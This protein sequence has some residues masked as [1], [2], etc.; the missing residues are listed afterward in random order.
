ML[1][2]FGIV[3]GL[4][5]SAEATNWK[6]GSLNV[7]SHLYG[8]SCPARNLCVAVGFGGTVATTTQPEALSSWQVASLPD[9]E[10]LEGNLRGVSCPSSALCVATD[11]SG[12]VWISSDPAA[13]ASAWTGIPVPGSKPYAVS[14]PTVSFCT[15]VGMKGTVL[16]SSEP[17]G[18][19]GAWTLTTLSGNPYMHAVSCASPVLCVA[20]D[21]SGAVWSTK[22]P[23]SGA[24][25]WSSG[26]LLS[27]NQTSTMAVACPLQ[28]FCVAG[29]AGEIFTTS[30]PTALGSAWQ[31][32]PLASR[33]QVLS[34]SC[35]TASLCA[36]G[37]DNGQIATS[38]DPSGGL[39][40]WQEVQ[41][42]DGTTNAFYGIS[43]PD[44]TLCVAVG[45]AGHVAV[46]EDPF[47]LTGPSSP[48]AA[49]ST[50]LFGKRFRRRRLKRGKATAGIRFHFTANGAVTGFECK[51]D[52]QR[53]LPCKAPRGYRL[54][55]GLHHFAVR[56][57]GPG[58]K[59]PT[60][61]KVRVEIVNPRP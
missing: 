32:S 47:D 58:G 18:G 49:P 15:A 19:A 57:F 26:G 1:L 29:D 9:Q 24:P 4:A 37:T 42:I 35:P 6:T 40:A 39:G 59:D 44:R 11:F 22:E 52:R 8:V 12:G 14:C 5:G 61:A 27:R 60:P 7:P 23:A 33:F 36:A 3:A 46:A 2:A 54:R 51:L 38:T 25:A 34:I 17:S 21:F 16:A 48:A 43:C 45:A 30:T 41:L 55:P 50:V 53:F 56:A 31:A 10:G 20:T 28:S 13:G